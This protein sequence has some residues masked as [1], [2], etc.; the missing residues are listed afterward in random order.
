MRLGVVSRAAP[1]QEDPNLSLGENAV[2]SRRNAMLNILSAAVLPAAQSLAQTA[3]SGADPVTVLQIQRRS[4]EVKGKPASILAVRQPDETPG[5]VTAVGRQFRVR[6]ENKLNV[7]TLMHWHG[8][9][10]PWQQDGVPGISGPPIPPGG[11]AD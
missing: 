7:P 9:T 2:L 11:S 6:L 4:I 8:L 1:A 3:S 5:L 10:P